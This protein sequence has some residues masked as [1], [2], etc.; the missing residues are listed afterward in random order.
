MT[1]SPPSGGPGTA[2]RR[3]RTDESGVGATEL[4]L[5]LPIL[6]LL[7]LGT[8]DVSRLVASRLDLEQAAQRTADL[9]LAVRPRTSDT[10]YLV[11][12]AMAASGQPSSN[13]T[14]ELFL[15]CAGV[16]QPSF[17]AA[18]PAGQLRARFVS[19]RIRGPYTPLFDWSALANVFGG[20]VLPPSITVTGD[21]VV[22]FQ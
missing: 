4:A 3:L 5:I 13:V 11:A 17:T 18:C 8:I 1:A 16:R 21:A 6:M 19:V 12:E 9:A 22:R 7:I 20:Q 15:E 2:L 14:V 10:S